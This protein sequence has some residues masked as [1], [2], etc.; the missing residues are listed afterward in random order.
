MK[1]TKGLI[2]TGLA[3]ALTVTLVTPSEAARRD[4]MLN[5]MLIGDID[6]IY[7][8]PQLTIDYVNLVRFEMGHS[9]SAPTAVE[10]DF[11]EPGEDDLTFMPTAGHAHAGT[12][13]EGLFVFGTK[14]TAMSISAGRLD[15]TGTHPKELFGQNA[16]VAP[17]EGANNGLSA[18]G[19]PNP[20]TV[21]DL[22]FAFDLGGDK[23]GVRLAIANSGEQ[24][25]DDNVDATGPSNMV[26]LLG[27]GYSTASEGL[28]LD[29]AGNLSFGSFTQYA[30]GDAVVEASN[31]GINLGGRGYYELD[32]ELSIGF[33]AGFGFSTWSAYNDPAD[34]TA[35]GSAWNLAVAAGPVYDIKDKAKVAGYLGL[36]LDGTGTDPSE[37]GDDDT[38]ATMNV[39]I[40]FVNL[41]AEIWV[42][43]W[44]AFR[45]GVGYNYVVETEAKDSPEDYQRAAHTGDFAWTAGLGF[46][47]EDFTF[48][49]TLQSGWLTDGPAALGG[50]GGGMFGTVAANYSF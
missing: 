10:T 17:G 20:W 39:A 42:F 25:A 7:T 46:K 27:G 16:A 34:D 14:T 6:D 30:N 38:S 50:T 8:F 41:A 29:L 45:A 5:N 13:G 40:P 35:V 4:A 37:E 47:V 28:K 43:D 23:A 21:A 3:F 32:E 9:A 1:W 24:S 15:L 22:N 18:Q 48:D 26:I 2:A 31:I 11:A 19:A 12:S 49:G 33:L 44:M 36:S